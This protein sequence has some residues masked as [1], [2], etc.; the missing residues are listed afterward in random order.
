MSKVIF[1]IFDF[2]FLDLGVN[3]QIDNSEIQIEILKDPLKKRDFKLI[4][5]TPYSSKIQTK[6]CKKSTIYYW[7]NTLTQSRFKLQ[8]NHLDSLVN[9]S[10]GYE[11]PKP[12]VPLLSGNSPQ[13]RLPKTISE[14]IRFFETLKS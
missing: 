8:I 6:L 2:N 7:T 12:E 4:L 13:S 5:N 3:Q 11:S 1:C 10:P 9:V 14:K